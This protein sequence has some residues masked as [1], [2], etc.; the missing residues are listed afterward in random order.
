M[1]LPFFE[2]LKSC[3]LVLQYVLIR[4]P[5]GVIG[6]KQHISTFSDG[7]F[8]GTAYVRVHTLQRLS[9]VGGGGIEGLPNK[10]A[11]DAALGFALT[12][13]CRPVSNDL[14]Q[15]LQRLETDE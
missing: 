14:A 13:H 11:P 7:W 12:S 6:E 10:L 5:R 15:Y 1:R 8:Q 9:G 2:F 4:M 3:R